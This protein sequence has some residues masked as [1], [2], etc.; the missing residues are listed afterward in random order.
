MFFRATSATNDA[1]GWAGEK[2]QGLGQIFGGHFFEKVT[3][4]FS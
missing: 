4:K 2:S 3:A 1:R